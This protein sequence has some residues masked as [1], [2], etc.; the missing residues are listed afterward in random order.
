MPEVDIPFEYTLIER[1]IIKARFLKRKKALGVGNPTLSYT[2]CKTVAAHRQNIRFPDG[3]ALPDPN[4]LTARDLSN[5][6]NGRMTRHDKLVIIDA[7]LKI[8]D[9]TP[10]Q[11]DDDLAA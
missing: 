2:M 11:F 6:E 3:T 9:Q 5:F 10:S 7:Y 4:G 8:V 1:D